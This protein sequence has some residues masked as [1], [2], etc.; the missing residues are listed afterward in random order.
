MA[1][2]R[3][4]RLATGMES[5]EEILSASNADWLKPRS[6]SRFLCNGMGIMEKPFKSL[7]KVFKMLLA[8]KSPNG[9]AISRTPENLRAWI[10]FLNTGFL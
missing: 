6:L 5:K 10:L 3:I 2:S 8:N 7:P 1:F 9:S 4:K